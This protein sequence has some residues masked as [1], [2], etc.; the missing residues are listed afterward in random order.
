M[1]EPND[2]AMRRA[3][4]PELPRELDAILRVYMPAI[5]KGRV[6]LTIEPEPG[7]YCKIVE[8]SV[9]GVHIEIR[10]IRDGERMIVQKRFGTDDEWKER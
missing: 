1:T 3:M 9:E 2:R 5:E 7:C 8:E 6:V 4:F 10:L